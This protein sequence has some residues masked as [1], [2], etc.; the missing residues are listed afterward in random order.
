MKYQNLQAVINNTIKN[1]EDEDIIN[2]L[3]DLKSSIEVIDDIAKTLNISFEQLK[4]ASDKKP[5]EVFELTIF[6]KEIENIIEY[7]KEDDI[8]SSLISLSNIL[9]QTESIVKDTPFTMEMVYKS[10]K[11]E[12]KEPAKKEE[13]QSKEEP[14]K[15]EKIEEQ[16]K[17]EK[18]IKKETSK[19]EKKAPAK[20]EETPSK[21]EPAKQEK[22][23]KKE[24][25]PETEDL[26]F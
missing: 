5:V 11:K 20:K 19:T 7:E 6:N 16:P 10:L 24:E 8:I 25:A 3:V 1:K 12:V 17:Q 21:E 14:A 15:Q 18:E 2:A 26:I 4:K 13:T 9:A 22:T 23:A